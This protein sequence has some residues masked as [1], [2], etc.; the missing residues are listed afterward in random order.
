MQNFSNLNNQNNNAMQIFMMSIFGNDYYNT[1][2][3]NNNNFN[4][5]NNNPNNYNN[6]NFNFNNNN[7][8][9]NNFNNN[10]F[11]FNN[12]SNIFNSNNFNNNNFNNKNFNF[13]N[14]NNNNPNNNAYYQ[15]IY[16]NYFSN[17][18]NSWKIGYI[19]NKTP[20]NT[21]KNP[22]PDQ[23]YN[24]VFKTT[25]GFTFNIP[26]SAKR[27][28]ND[29]VQ[30]FFKRVDREDLINKNVISM[31]FNASKIPF[32]SKDKIINLFRNNINPIIM[33]LDVQNLIGA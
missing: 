29:L 11:N 27:T 24:C 7:F 14:Q 15:N 13:N 16:N 20:A 19:A 33:V 28:I 30:T 32:K 2:Y 9:N 4:N 18:N 1:I 23:L 22:T 12:N 5:N 17:D 3:P 26:F 25:Q 8:N 31:L 21:P 10:N 6:N